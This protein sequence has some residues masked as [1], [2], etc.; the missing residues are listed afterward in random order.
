M[1]TIELVNIDSH[2]SISKEWNDN[3]DADTIEKEASPKLPETL[4]SLR[5]LHLFTSK[6][7]LH[8]LISKLE[9]KM[10]D[11]ILIGTCPSK[12]V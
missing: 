4:D 8:V 11:L 10:T 12:T 2:I 1:K 6:P 3:I 5:R 7:K 9:S